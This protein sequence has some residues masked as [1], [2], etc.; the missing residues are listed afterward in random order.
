MPRRFSSINISPMLRCPAI[1]QQST[2]N[3]HQSTFNTLLFNQQSPLPPAKKTNRSTKRLFKF[4]KTL[5]K[6]N[7]RVIHDQQSTINNPNFSLKFNTFALRLCASA[8]RLYS[9]SLALLTS[10]LTQLI[11]LI[12]GPGAIYRSLIKAILISHSSSV[13]LVLNRI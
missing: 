2:I 9:F 10:C 1:D 3:N 13:T 12:K 8:H 7:N 11:R 5:S 6:L 4:L